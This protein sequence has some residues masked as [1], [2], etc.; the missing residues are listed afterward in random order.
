[1][2]GPTVTWVVTLNGSVNKNKLV[3][4][5]PGVPPQTTDDWG[6][7]RFAAGYPLY[8][9]WAPN[10]T[11][12]ATNGI[13]EPDD[14]TLSPNLVYT[15]SSLPT[16]EVSFATHVALWKGAVSLSALFDYRGGFRVA[17]LNAY[18]QAIGDQ[19]DY[20]SNFKNA[21]LWEQARNVESETINVTG[22][23]GIYP[24][25][26]GYYEDGTY[27]RFRELSL[28]YALPQRLAHVVRMQTLS[29][30]GAVRNLALWTRYGGSDPEVSSTE[31]LNSALSPTS[32]TNVINNDY[33]EDMQAIP[34]LRYWVVRLNLGI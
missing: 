34:L 30:T 19:T 16:Q 7:F 28:T 24:P 9:Y 13:V 17:D 25:A 2:Q 29:L 1:M 8:G 26:K 33:R 14:V 20:A 27:V 32:N 21:P 15:G 5:A 22:L 31:G 10:A 12:S 6:V 11:Y 23:N 3:S 4:L 18:F